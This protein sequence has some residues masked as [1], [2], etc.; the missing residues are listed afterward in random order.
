MEKYQGSAAAR[1]RVSTISEHVIVVPTSSL[2][3]ADG[4]V[5]GPHLVAV[6][7][8]ATIDVNNNSHIDDD[9]TIQTDLVEIIVGPEWNVQSRVSVSPTVAIAGFNSERP[10]E[11]DRSKW[12]IEQVRVFKEE[13][14]GS[15]SKR[16]GLLLNLLIQ[17]GGNGWRTFAYHVVANGELLRLPRGTD[18]TSI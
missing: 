3:L 10:D 16:I 4:T 1:V 11:M 7:G 13:P 9:V 2:R 8:I 14:A 17:G 12:I 18:L 15:P 6:S 5:T